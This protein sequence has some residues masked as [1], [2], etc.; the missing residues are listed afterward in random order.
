[1]A[2]V[3]VKLESDGLVWGPMDDEDVAEFLAERHTEGELIAAEYVERHTM[4]ALLD[5]LLGP[6]AR[7]Q[8]GSNR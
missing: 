2:M 7:N 6:P 8:E 5:V 3:Y 1:M 4:S